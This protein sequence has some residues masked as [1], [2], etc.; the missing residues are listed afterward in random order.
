MPLRT[1]VARMVLGAG[2]GVGARHGITLLPVGLVFDQPGTFRSG[3]ALVLIGD[4]VPT[5]PPLARAEHDPE[6]AV[7]ELT[8]RVAAALR[9]L[10]VE[11]NDRETLRLLDLAEVLWRDTARD[12][13]ANAAERAAWKQQTLRAVRYLAARE[14]GRLDALRR[15]L[16]DHVH[17]LALVG[18][19][20]ESYSRGA[21]LRYAIREGGS[22]ALGLPL[23]L[24]GLVIHAA[25]Y[26]LTALTVRSRR[27]E[28]DTE[29]TY[30][31]GFGLLF[32]PLGWCVEAWIAWW[33][34]GPLGLGLFAVSLI[35]AGFFAL[36][37]QERLARVRRDARAFVRFLLDRD[38]HQRLLARRRALVDELRALAALVPDDVLAGRV[39]P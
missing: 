38:L 17:D 36:A 9:R 8:D 37:W 26:Q 23:A 2:R 15:E 12:L 11:A 4:P 35:P 20:V 30:K 34:A 7:R 33:I 13:A 3:S 32:Y 25:P 10:I 1:G 5:E 28:P 19:A 27:V 16:G 24:W 21:V 14:P 18:V 29:A 6:G 39:K 22:L 31:L